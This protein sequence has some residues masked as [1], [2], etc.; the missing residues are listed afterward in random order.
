MTRTTARN[1]RLNHLWH[2]RRGSMLPVLAAGVA[3][4]IGFA[5]FAIDASALYSTKHKLQAGAD[6]AVLAAASQL[7][8]ETAVRTTGVAYAA[9]NLP[10]THHGT[11]LVTNDV[12]LGQ[13]DS[14]TRT[15]TPG[16][17]PPDAVQVTVRRTAANGNAVPT[18]FARILGYDEIDIVVTAIASSTDASPCLLALEPDNQSVM[19]N[20]NS[21]INANGCKVQVNSTAPD[22]L[23]TNSASSVTADEICVTGDYQ[24]GGYSPAP[25]TGCAPDPDPLASLAPPPVGGCDHTDKVVNGGVETLTPGTYCGKLEI[26]AG[27][28]GNFEPGVYILDDASLIA[29]S[30]SMIQ[31]DGV[32]FYLRGSDGYLN[33][34]S[35]SVV[36]VSAPTAGQ[37][38]EGM[39]F[40]Q[41]RN[42]PPGTVHR[43]NSDSTTSLEGTVYLPAGEVLIN[44]GSTIG[45]NASYTSFIARTFNINSDSTL[46]LNSDYAASPVPVPPGLTANQAALV[47]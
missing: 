2:D 21:A 26:N 36:D 14:G 20:S 32:F 41:D 45:G 16:A 30:G 11:A 23:E 13:W 19:V 46:Q 44:S 28:V 31:G 22:A 6:A 33:F 12:V 47:D 7:P 18:F 43:F 9:K 42:A 1:N 10:V 17:N 24:G 25:Q 4:G 40:F 39:L 29:N 8:N 35:G 34:N 27:G 3:L 38:Y 37:P 15:F 5:S